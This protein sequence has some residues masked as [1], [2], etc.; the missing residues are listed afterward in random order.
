MENIKLEDGQIRE[1]NILLNQAQE[2]NIKLDVYKKDADDVQEQAE[3]KMQELRDYYE[4]NGQAFQYNPQDGTLVLVEEENEEEI[5][6][7]EV[8]NDGEEDSVEVTS[9]RTRKKRGR[10]RKKALEV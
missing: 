5:S 1:L 2:F 10:P 8:N 4:L 7:V 9:G 6:T 3:G